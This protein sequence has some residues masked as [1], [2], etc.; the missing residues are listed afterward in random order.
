MNPFIIKEPT[1]ISFSGGRTSA[2]MLHKVIEANNGLPSDA[3]VCFANTGKEH[4]NTLQFVSDCQNKWNIDIKWLEFR[5]ID[6]KFELVTFE[7]ASRNGEPFEQLI[8]K[9]NYLPNPVARFCTEE[10]KVKTIERYLRSIGLEDYSMMVGVRA[11]EQRR[12]P[13]LRKR[14]LLVPLADAGL[15]QD[16]VQAYWKNSDFDLQ[17]EFRDGVTAMGNCD[18]CFLK[19]PHQ[20]MGLVKNYPEMATWWANMENKIGATFRSDRPSYSQLQGF[21]DKQANMFDTEGG[22][23][24]FCGD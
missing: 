7:T 1:I 6:P 20:I 5:S 22:I 19:G 16:D 3:I 12:L 14:G 13:K 17:L 10:L 18:L 4:P 9:K 15:T 23:S 8:I 24:C 21:V 11:D 2:F